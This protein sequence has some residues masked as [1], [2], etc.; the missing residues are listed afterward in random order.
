MF[1]DETN[2]IKVN[3]ESELWYATSLEAINH[4]LIHSVTRDVINT[5]KYNDIILD[6]SFEV[7]ESISNTNDEFIADRIMYATRNTHELLTVTLSE[8]QVKELLSQETIGK[9]ENLFNQ[10]VGDFNANTRPNQ[11]KSRESIKGSSRD[12]SD[13]NRENQST[14]RVD[15]ESQSSQDDIRNTSA[16][17]TLQATQVQ[18]GI[19]SSLLDKPFTLQSGLDKLLMN[20]DSYTIG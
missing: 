9:L 2:E 7:M 3:V 13:S 1:F 12:V 19:D 20:A 10:I 5:G 17:E 8:N 6:L 16:N 14:Q 15:R 11:S 18:V 4:E